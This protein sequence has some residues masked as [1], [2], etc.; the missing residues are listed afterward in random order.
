MKGPSTVDWFSV[1]TKLQREGLGHGQ[2]AKE[3]GVS[4]RT[5]GNWAQQ[6]SEPTYSRGAAL[7]EIFNSVVKST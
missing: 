7:L 2:L 3:V 1:I 6:I 4:R 5:I